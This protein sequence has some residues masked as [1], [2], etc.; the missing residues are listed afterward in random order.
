M[1]KIRMFE[2]LAVIILVNYTF[3]C[4]F[5]VC[6]YWAIFYIKKLWEMKLLLN[7]MLAYFSHYP[8]PALKLDYW[9]EA[10]CQDQK[11]GSIQHQL[12]HNITWNSEGAIQFSIE[13]FI[14]YSG[15]YM[16]WSNTLS[17]CAS[18]YSAKTC[19]TYIIRQWRNSIL[20]FISHQR[21]RERGENPQLYVQFLDT[22]RMKSCAYLYTYLCMYFLHNCTGK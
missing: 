17:Y 8:T 16:L 15:F 22:C 13:N 7:S 10:S 1:E 18:S 3:L 12:W 6:N 20:L 21:W 19:Y 9:R 4:L 2:N 5:I 11:I 14:V